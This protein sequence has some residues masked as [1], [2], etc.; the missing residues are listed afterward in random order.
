MVREK[1]I[2]ANSPIAAWEKQMN[3]R[4]QVGRSLVG[5]RDY[6]LVCNGRRVNFRS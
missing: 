3:D 6:E 1:I 2:A 5:I 4:P